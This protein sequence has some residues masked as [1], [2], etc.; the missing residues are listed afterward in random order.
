MLVSAVAGLTACRKGTATS[1]APGEPAR[2]SAPPAESASAPPETSAAGTGAPV[3]AS[4]WR[5]EALPF[6]L[7]TPVPEASGAGWLV[8]DGKLSLVV[9]GDSGNRGAY[10]VVDPE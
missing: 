9:V 3:A 10:G 5:C 1:G 4:G 8:I 7:T 2:T 6:A